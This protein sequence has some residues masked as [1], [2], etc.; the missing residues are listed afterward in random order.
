MTEGEAQAYLSTF[1]S[2]ETLY[3]LQIYVDMLVKWQ[4]AINLVASA[5]VPD[6][7]SRHIVDSA[8]I[9][10]LAEKSRG[11]WLDIGSG[12]GF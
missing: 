7:W 3:R 10:P 4:K 8:Q 12:G 11:K 5:T 9:F 2:R 6:A 1:V